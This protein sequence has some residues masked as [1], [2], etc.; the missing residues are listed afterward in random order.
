MIIKIVK[1]K[2]FI[3]ADIDSP[4][5]KTSQPRIFCLYQKRLSGFTV[6]V[7]PAQYWPRCDAE[8]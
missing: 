2:L 5:R 1:K 3:V 4:K 7:D 8:C 6:L